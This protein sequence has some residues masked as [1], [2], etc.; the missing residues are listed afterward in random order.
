MADPQ[1]R[2]DTSNN[3]CDIRLGDSNPKQTLGP[4]LPSVFSAAAANNVTLL[5]QLSSSGANMHAI[6]DDSCNALHAAARA[7]KEQ[8]TEYLLGLGLPSIINKNNRLPVHEAALSGDWNTLKLLIEHRENL[9][10]SLKSSYPTACSSDLADLIVQSEQQ[11]MIKSWIEYTGS[12]MI[13]EKKLSILHRAAQLK[14]A[15]I[16]GILLSYNI[17]NI[18][19]PD[20][21]G[22]TPIHHAARNKNPDI[23]R[24]ILLHP[25]THVNILTPK[26]RNRGFSALEMAIRK[27]N[28]ETFKIL[29]GDDRLDWSAPVRELHI[30]ED[31][32]RLEMWKLL[33]K[34]HWANDTNSDFPLLNA[35]VRGE[36]NRIVELLAQGCSAMHYYPSPLSCLV[37]MGHSNI[38]RQLLLDSNKVDLQINNGVSFHPLQIAVSSN[39]KV[40][41]QS[42][43]ESTDFLHITPRTIE[44]AMRIDDSKRDPQ[45]LKL[46][47]SDPRV[48]WE[49]S[50]RS[51][52]YQLMNAAMACNGTD[53]LEFWQHFSANA[54]EW[55]LARALDHTIRNK[56]TDLSDLLRNH[57]AKTVE[58]LYSQKADRERECECREYMPE[59][60]RNSNGPSLNA[61]TTQVEDT[62]F[63]RLV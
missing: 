45:I 13:T 59:I 30:C 31:W 22:Y 29:L 19:E 42:L 12:H 61:Q 40:M 21:N 63:Q 2:L 10:E 56:R 18:N 57:G 36:E 44:E 41:V 33:V 17:S 39:D 26:H 46:L 55:F 24:Q 3:G 49:F 48:N 27:N 32:N 50:N 23:I 16:L 53:I 37:A 7:G 35:C 8:A 52:I 51:E 25:D 15:S 60:A 20:S 54:T 5:Q 47:L 58:E 14:N 11:V 62:V 38:A 34:H 9:H 43:L 1:P 4:V 6:T 28:L